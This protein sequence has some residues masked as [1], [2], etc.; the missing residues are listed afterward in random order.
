[1]S[2]TAM[3]GPTGKSARLTVIVASLVVL[4][5]TRAD[6]RGARDSSPVA[7]ALLVL[8]LEPPDH[9]VDQDRREHAADE[10][11]QQV[12]AGGVADREPRA[13][14]DAEHDHVQG[15]HHSHSIVPGGLDVMSRT[16][17][18]TSRI[19]PIMREAICSSRSYGSRAQSAVI[20][21]SEVTAR[22]ATT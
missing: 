13:H 2:V 14:D 17:R 5:Y 7:A 3:A 19:S 12:A 15:A 20:A 6:P 11:R 8:V 10:A 18:L 16:T 4:A 21:S 1:M 22:M 9:Q